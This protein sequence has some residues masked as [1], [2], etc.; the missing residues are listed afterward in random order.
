MT[1]QNKLVSST[2]LLAAEEFRNL[3]FA[4]LDY[5]QRNNRDININMLIDKNSSAKDGLLNQNIDL[6]ADF[7]FITALER[8]NQEYHT[9]WEA[10]DDQP[11]LDKI[12]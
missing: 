6:N 4:L 8:A 3:Y 7:R 1:A 10:H 11:M 2:I 9:L 5:A 12:Y